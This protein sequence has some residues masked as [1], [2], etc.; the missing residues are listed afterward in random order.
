MAEE[1]DDKDRLILRELKREAGQKTATLARRLGIPRTTLHERIARLEKEGIIKRRTILVD[2]AKL[3]RPVTAFVFVAF[4]A[5]GVDQRTLA[6]KIA[7]F[8]EITEVF[9]ISGEWD[10]LIKARSES[11]PAVG[12]LIVDRLRAMPGVARTMTATSFETIKEEP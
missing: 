3:G 5:G 7:E 9:V 11:L 1:M 4:A 8:P 6:Q 10:I 12:R 2:H